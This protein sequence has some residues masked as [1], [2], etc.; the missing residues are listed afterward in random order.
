MRISNNFSM[1]N[2]I[3]SLYNRKNLYAYNSVN[4]TNFGSNNSLPEF[5]TKSDKYCYYGR[6]P[7]PNEFEQLKKMGITTI[8]NLAPLDYTPF[9]EKYEAEKNGFEYYEIPLSAI[10]SDPTVEQLEQFFDIMEDVQDNDKKM[11]IH[12]QYGLQRTGLMVALYQR[13][14]N[15][16][17]RELDDFRVTKLLDKYG[18]KFD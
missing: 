6:K 14:N 16:P 18:Y 4:R 2:G 15:I 8:V 1:G 17:N 11:Y 5:V 7:L 9:D 13:C 3:F 10:F 12:C